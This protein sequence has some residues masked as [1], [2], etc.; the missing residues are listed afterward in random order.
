M[1][2]SPLLY[3]QFEPPNIFLLDLILKQPG[4]GIMFY[5]F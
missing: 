3:V 1:R 4:E 5:D 2:Q